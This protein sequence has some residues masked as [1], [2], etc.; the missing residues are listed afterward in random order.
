MQRIYA[1]LFTISLAKNSVTVKPWRHIHSSLVRMG[2]SAD[3]VGAYHAMGLKILDPHV[4]CN[5]SIRQMYIQYTCMRHMYILQ[6]NATNG[7]RSI[8]WVWSAGVLR[9]ELEQLGQPSPT[10][11]RKISR[12][13]GGRSQHLAT[14]F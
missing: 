4:F 3:Q 13:E 10:T 7:V 5:L 14:V 12:S 6:S 11:W 2:H 8:V 1:I 9:S